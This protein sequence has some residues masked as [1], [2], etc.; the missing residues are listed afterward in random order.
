MLLLPKVCNQ[1][2]DSHI[3]LQFMLIGSRLYPGAK[4]AR[5]NY[6]YFCLADFHVC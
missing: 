1:L 5:Y 3:Q 4:G 2:L 6:S